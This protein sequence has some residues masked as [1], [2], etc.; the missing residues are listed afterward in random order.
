MFRIETEKE[1]LSAFRSR[2]RKFVE[3]PK[4]TR[5]PLFIRDYLAWVDPYGVR[6]FLVFTAP[7]AQRPTGI[8]FRRDQQGDKT[9]A[10]GVCDWCRAAGA[11][12]Q[13]GLLTTDVDSK[14]R[15]G[16]NVC[17]DLRCG[18]KLEAAANLSGRSVLDDNRQLIERMARFA[19]EALGI[20]F[21][22]DA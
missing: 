6:V 2:D 18:E 9:S 7:G 8:A 16:V 15:V 11:S 20:E 22:S 13:I 17:L 21:S 14:R 12:D 10:T 1:L 4:G 19:S 5:V 3:L